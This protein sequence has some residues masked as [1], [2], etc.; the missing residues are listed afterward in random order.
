M[1]QS[2]DARLGRDSTNHDQTRSRT[3]MAVGMCP[4][5]PG[6]DHDWWVGEFLVL[7]GGFMAV[8]G[9]WEFVGWPATLIIVGGAIA[10]LG[11]K[12]L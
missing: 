2:P 12:V 10:A 9:S 5:V 3:T 8:I 4:H 6:G 11:W 1:C 7:V